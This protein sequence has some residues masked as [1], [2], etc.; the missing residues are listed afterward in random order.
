MKQKSF[1]L[2]LKWSDGSAHSPAEVCRTTKKS[3][4]KRETRGRIQ[5][6]KPKADQKMPQNKCIQLTLD[7][8][9]VTKTSDPGSART[10]GG[11]RWRAWYSKVLTIS[12]RGMPWIVL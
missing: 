8:S 2:I 9:M 12:L 4:T 5:I 1:L 10:T 11:F 3:N 7:V 6:G